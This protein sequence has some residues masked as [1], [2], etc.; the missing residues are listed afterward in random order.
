MIVIIT[1]PDVGTPPVHAS[2]P[3]R[4]CATPRPATR[5]RDRCHAHATHTR[6]G[7]DRV[8]RHLV[9]DRP[10]TGLTATFSRPTE[11]RSEPRTASEGVHA[12]PLMRSAVSH[13]RL[14]PAHHPGRAGAGA[15]SVLTWPLTGPPPWP[16]GRLWD[17]PGEF[18]T[19]AVHEG[20]TTTAPRR[21]RFRVAAC[22]SGTQ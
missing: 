1:S 8:H 14:H 4:T 9:T 5:V 12:R 10:Y 21:Q 22:R 17:A 7:P 3:E 11:S 15:G 19:G 13:F 6:T 20:Q 2:A 16:G 18:A